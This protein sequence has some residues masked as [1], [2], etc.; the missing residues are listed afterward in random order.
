MESP[1]FGPYRLQELLGE[2]AMGSVW[3][4]LDLRLERSVA[5]KLLKHADEGRH[6]ALVAEAKMASRLNHP[7]VAHIYEA[8]EVEGVPFIA[9]ELVE[10]PTLRY[11]VGHRAEPEWLADVARQAAEGLRHAHG[12][13][14]VHRDIKPENLV[15][16]GDGTL[17][18]LDFG[19]ARPHGAKAEAGI[20]HHQTLIDQTAPG[21]SQGTPAYMSPEQANGEAVGPATDQFSL[22]VVLYQLATGIHPFLRNNLVETLFAVVKDRPT[23]LKELRPDLPLTLSL[24]VERLMAKASQD[25]Y[26]TLDQFLAELRGEAET[27][28][29]KPLPPSRRWGVLLGIAFPL[30]LGAILLGMFIHRQLSRNSGGVFG[31][32]RRAAGEDF[33]AGRQVLAVLPLERMGG[34]DQFDWL[35]SSLADSMA[36]ALAKQSGLVV[37][38]RL[39]VLEAL[40]QLGEAPGKPLRTLG[41]LGASLQVQRV[42]Q[43]SYLVAGDRIR[44]TA[45]LVDL[46]LGT[47]LHQFRLEGSTKDLMALEDQLQERVSAELGLG[48]ESGT[49]QTRARQVRTRELFTKGNQILVEGNREAIQL[50]RRLYQEAVDLEPDY[51][52]ARAALAWALMEDGTAMALGSGK[53]MESQGVILEARAQ[54]DKALAQDP[55][56]AQGYRALSASLLRLNDLEGASRAALQSLRLDPTD[57]RAYSVLAEVFLELEGDDNHRTAR[58]YFEKALQ[59][60]PERWHTHHRYAVLLQNE[61]ELEASLKQAQRAIQLQPSAEL[62]FVT[63]ADV[64]LWLGRYD[65]AQTTI[66]G[67]VGTNPSSRILKSLQAYAAWGRQDREAFERQ[68]KELQGAWPPGHGN[69]VLL[70]GL[71]DLLRGEQA[72]G[73]ARFTEHLGAL[74]GRGFET[75]THNEK[76]VASLNLYFMARTSVL[77]GQRQ[78]AQELLAASEIL[79][80]GKRKVAKADPAFRR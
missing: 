44:I 37:V 41:R 7:N 73:V 66:A 28:R 14:V 1:I 27:I 52:P 43:G 53:F 29:V 18:V 45:S 26:P 6:R 76:R 64:L 80:A 63:A 32:A 79:H 2:G 20:T 24:A 48:K 61:G 30:I 54:A 56:L 23:P 22:G 17:K 15:L 70:A 38:D 12:H 5:L 39:R 65:E 8:G 68:A 59:L 77:V 11:F 46:K 16:R 35:S 55:T 9:M 36:F 3:R 67:G 21:Y 58:R 47:T 50:A 78:A 19:I 57:A 75:L 69:T 42:V 4:A 51:A 71:T 49:S 33:A 10:G 13:G 74:R 34:E 72:A 60:D 31:E 40:H 25:R 62:A